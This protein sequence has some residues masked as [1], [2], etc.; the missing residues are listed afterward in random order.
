MATETLLERIKR[1][2]AEAV[3]AGRYHS[4]TD[5]LN[6]AGL[7]SGYFGEFEARVAANPKAGISGKTARRFADLLG[8][9][10]ETIL[11]G[12]RSEEPPYVDV[13]EERAWAVHAARSLRLSEAAIQLVLKEDPGG[14]DPGRMYWFRR[15]E[16]ED[17][18]VRPSA[19]SGRHKI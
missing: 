9:S 16:S 14:A 19:E 17:E 15:I 7:S 18:R 5:F 13:F 10:L 2:V 1:L 11:S 12:E 6:R 8:V 3:R 4:P